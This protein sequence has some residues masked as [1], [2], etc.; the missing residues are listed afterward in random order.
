MAI[1][2]A[3]DVAAYF[4]KQG[5]ALF[6]CSLDAEGAFDAI[7]HSVLFRKTIGIIPDHLWCLL[8]TWYHNMDVSIRMNG[9]LGRSIRV[10]RG[11]RQGGL[12]SPFI[13]NVFY[14]ELVDHINKS[15]CGVSVGSN[16][17]SV[18]CYADDLL[19]AS[20]TAVGLQRI[21]NLCES[22]ISKHGLRFNPSKTS[23]TIVGKNPF[24]KEPQWTLGGCSLQNVETFTYLGA[25]LGNKGSQEY[26]D[27]RSKAARISHYSLENAGLYA[28]GLEP[29]AVSHVYRLGIQPVLTYASH[30][31]HLS[32]SQVQA[33][34]VMQGNLIKWSLGLSK[35]SRSTPLIT[36][37]NIQPIKKYRDHQA[38][39]LL[40]RCLLG[41]SLA[42]TFYW[43]LLQR[44]H[45]QGN[46]LL[47]RAT[48]A[49]REAGVTL[50][51]LLLNDLDTKRLFGMNQRVT[52]GLIDSL[53]NTFN[54]F[55][56]NNR[57]LAQLLLYVD[58]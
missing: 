26:V 35:F 50:P 16:C 6:T 45:T 36:A 7:P 10:R 28:G 23:C 53:R 12:T 1:S 20:T 27:R 42:A 34:S 33:L 41:S 3:H 15:E 21:I 17:F 38:V 18:F 29:Y 11:T 9:V 46:T 37:L 5:S 25:E 24:I 4:N 2:L 47:A 58:F 14:E 49:M 30:A 13:F 48:S 39:M 8:Y 22:Y 19:I 43:S 54:D 57:Q 32:D 56:Q 44:G 51:N 52:N 55:N 40:K 31:L